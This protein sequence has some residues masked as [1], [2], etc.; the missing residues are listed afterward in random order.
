M[1]YSGNSNHDLSL[2]EAVKL[3]EAFRRANPD[4][5]TVTTLLFGL[6]AAGA[7][8][9]QEGRTGIRIYAGENSSAQ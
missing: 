4:T 5:Q 2:D 6:K 7:V 3:T 9:A 8:L 1:Y